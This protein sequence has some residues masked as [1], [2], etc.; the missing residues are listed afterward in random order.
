MNEQL[1]TAL[2][3]FILGIIIFLVHSKVVYLRNRCDTLEETILNAFNLCEEQNEFTMNHV[4][5]LREIVSNDTNHILE[6]VCILEKE[7]KNKHE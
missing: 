4:K 5:E 7:I 2:S 6:M 1:L 3:I